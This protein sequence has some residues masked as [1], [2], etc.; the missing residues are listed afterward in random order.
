MQ[1]SFVICIILFGVISTSAETECF[2]CSSVHTVAECKTTK[3][4]NADEICFTD[5]LPQGNRTL[6]SF[7]CRSE[8]N[9]TS[10][11]SNTG[12]MTNGASLV[13]R[14]L[15][16][17]PC[18]QCC[19]EH[20]CNRH[21]CQ[22]TYSL[23]ECSDREKVGC[24]TL[25]QFANICA[26]TQRALSVCRRFCGLCSYVDGQWASW[27]S[28]SRCDVTCGDG[29]QSRKRTCTE[30]APAGGGHNCQGHSDETQMCTLQPCPVH[31]HWS[32]W[33]SWGSCSTTCGIGMQ[34]RDRTCSNPYPARFGDHCYGDSRDD[35]LCVDAICPV[36]DGGWSTWTS[37]TACTASCGGGIKSHY[38]DCNSPMPSAG[39]KPCSG[40]PYEV[41][42]CNQ[43]SCPRKLSSFFYSHPVNVGRRYW[44]P[45]SKGSIKCTNSLLYSGCGTIAFKTEVFEEGSYYDSTTGVFTCNYPGVY[46]FTPSLISIPHEGIDCDVSK[47]DQSITKIVKEFGNWKASVSVTVTLHL[48]RGDKVS[49]FCQHL[50]GDL[51][52][53]STFS[54][55]LLHSDILFAL[56]WD[57]VMLTDRQMAGGREG[58]LKDHSCTNYEAMQIS[59][60]ICIILVAVIS[61]SAAIECFACSS[62]QTVAECKTTK[63]CNADEICYTDFL[64]QGNATLYSFGCRSETNCSSVV[65]Y[66]GNMTNGALLVGRSLPTSSCSEC[67]KE[68][69]CN[70][71]MCQETY[72]LKECSDRENVGCATLEQ[73]ADICADTHRALSVCRRFCGLCRYV[74]GQWASWLAW[75]SCDVTCGDGNQSRK[76]TCTE[77]VPAGRG[78][79]CQGHS[80]ETQRCTLQ[81]CPVH[82]HWSTWSDWGSCS[83]TCGIGMQRRDRTCS[84]P[85]PARF[86]DHCYGDSRDDRLC[87]D[88]VCP[89]T[90]G[91]WSKWTSWSTCTAS[92]GGGVKSHYRDCNNPMP[93]AGGRLCTGLQQEMTACNQQNCPRK[94]SSFS[95][96]HPVSVGH[97]QYGGK[98][99]SMVCYEFTVIGSSI[100]LPTCSTIAFTSKIFEEG[101]S[102]NSTTGD[103]TCSYPGVYVFTAS[104]ISSAGSTIDCD[105]SKNDHT[106]ARI[107]K[108]QS[109]TI[110]FGFATITLQLQLRD[111]ISLFCQH[112]SDHLE[113]SST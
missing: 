86:G 63:T 36:T 106:I 60:V 92:C 109:E 15:T 23:K 53:A 108:N 29:N 3:T 18:S 28:W 52:S 62:V 79:N 65:S 111:K 76:R 48:Q 110:V 43:Q 35:R 2:A 25:E 77:P 1:I 41:A 17:S 104:V 44:F 11:V 59:F 33:S 91:A 38:R 71:H 6:Y 75:S 42:S 88:A 19:K 31:G 100:H 74:D 69:H 40:A 78:H 45:D 49:L 112:L 46:V 20:H 32:T 30:P 55:F 97:L 82:G 84:N 94:L 101:S 37:W 80:D 39:V 26:D 73:Y 24:A 8:T 64:L 21:I 14:S 10:V 113:P 57:Q 90:D 58:K 56:L 13:G 99:G 98:K 47:N 103:F 61:T 50:D 16:A 83:T 27:L 96:S 5:F 67:C 4:C 95:Y 22:Q 89:V 105:I 70:R 9:C 87:V 12:N 68:H 72:S 102:Y 107:I 54:G 7:G 93:S 85:Y 51:D 66:S 81:P 34:R